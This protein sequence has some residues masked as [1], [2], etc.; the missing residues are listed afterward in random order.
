M[1]LSLTVRTFFISASVFLLQSFKP[2]RNP[3]FSPSPHSLQWRIARLDYKSLRELSNKGEYGGIFSNLDEK[4][5]KG[6]KK[7]NPIEHFAYLL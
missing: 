7:Q 6:L 5:E 3:N 4:T 2:E 1:A